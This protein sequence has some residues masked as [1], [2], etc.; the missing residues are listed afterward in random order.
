MSVFW[1]FGIPFCLST[2]LSYS[3]LRTQCGTSFRGVV[4]KDLIRT[5]I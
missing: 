3:D 2:V 4:G 1:D 5:L